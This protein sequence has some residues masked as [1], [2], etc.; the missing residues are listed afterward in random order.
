M[1]R[2]DRWLL[3]E[4]VEEV[5]PPQALKLETLRRDILDLYQAW[6][7]ELVITPLIEF[8]D[9]LLVGSSHDL[10][11]H[12]FKITDQLSGRMMG[13]RADITPQVARMDAR[14]L[15]REGPARLCYADSVLHTR[16]NGLLDSRVP[17]RVGAEMFGHAGTACDVELIVL[18]A[19]TLKLAGIYNI[20]IVLGH[21]GLFRNLMVAAGLEGD[22]ES[23]LFDCFQRKAYGDLD[24]L[25]A[26]NL[27]G[28]TELADML[29]SLSRLSGDV[30]VLDQADQVFADAPGNV[31]AAL[32]EIRAIAERVA[33]RLPEVTLGFDLSELR[34][35]QY[36]TGMVFAAYT[37]GYGRAVAKG[38]RFD[39][40]GEVFGRARP[41]SGF[42][43]DLKILARL[44][45]RKYPR[46]CVILAPDQDVPE[47]Q[48]LVS[49]LRADGQTVVTHLG[50]EEP[51]A[52]L[53]KE[54]GCTRRI[55]P[56]AAGG[57]QVVD[58]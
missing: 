45:T 51:D 49:S 32:A 31:R 5:L 48:Q 43:A 24:A 39:D 16:P 56:D 12:T 35:Y 57:W 1:T 41:A 29:R 46:R 58:I 27:P 23:D 3:P 47:L 28:S 20:H 9:S 8:L 25:L 37:P 33:R 55:V 10:D 14:N 34:G 50:S 4:G 44:S 18:M 26:Q 30:S 17:I 6:G 38:G 7:Y 53:V 13:V 42:D 40:I 54:L 36:H 11:I 21:V 15:H 22:A 19:Q 2:A 52:A